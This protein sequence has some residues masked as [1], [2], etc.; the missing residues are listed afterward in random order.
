MGSPWGPWFPRAGPQGTPGDPKGSQGAPQGA[1]TQGGTQGSRPRPTRQ[2]RNTRR[3]S[4]RSR[5]SLAQRLPGGGTSYVREQRIMNC[6]LL[7][8]LCKLSIRRRF[9]RRTRPGFGRTEYVLIDFKPIYLINSRMM[10]RASLRACA[11]LGA[12][13][14]GERRYLRVR[15][16]SISIW[17]N[18]IMKLHDLCQPTS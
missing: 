1:G 9:E 15:T 4:W 12:T 11:D 6:H 7:L 10:S 5:R 14:T 16:S 18:R 13:E 3:G 8:L 2:G 17:N